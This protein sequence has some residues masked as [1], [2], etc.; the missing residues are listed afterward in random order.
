MLVNIVPSWNI[1]G[2]EIASVR[3]SPNEVQYNQ[4]QC[5]N[6]FII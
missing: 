4:Y 3:K 6:P 5:N 2:R 1:E